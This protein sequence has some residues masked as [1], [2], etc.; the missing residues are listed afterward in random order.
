[1]T[2]AARCT[3]NSTLRIDSREPSTRTSRRVPYATGR[4]GCATSGDQVHPPKKGDA[5]LA[6]CL[7]HAGQKMGK[8]STRRQLEATDTAAPEQLPRFPKPNSCFWDKPLCSLK[9]EC[10]RSILGGNAKRSSR[11]R[12]TQSAAARPAGEDTPC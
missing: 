6:L 8:E 9:P 3:L 12:M 10:L 2:F 5:S 1:M 4:D 7:G 11:E